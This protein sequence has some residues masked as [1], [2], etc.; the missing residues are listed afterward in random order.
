[1]L[2]SGH[3]KLLSKREN[4]TKNFWKHALCSQKCVYINF[5]QFRLIP[6]V[7]VTVGIPIV[8]KSPHYTI[9][10]RSWQV[11]SRI[12]HRLSGW[13]LISVAV[14][15]LHTLLL[16][17]LAQITDKIKTL[18]VTLDN[19]LTFDHHVSSISKSCFF[20]IRAFRHIRAALTQEMANSVAVSLVTS[21]LDN[22][23]S[24]LY[25]TSQ[26]NLNKLQRIQNT[27]TK[28]VDP[29]HT[30]SSEAL[31]TL[32]WF[33]VRQRINFKIATLTFKLL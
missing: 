26:T 23:N 12:N 7:L 5:R 10:A 2:I 13:A 28:L 24:L 17:L 3:V 29:N 20:H 1:M 15:Y 21:R 8:T 32:H 30:C 27:L 25:G 4:N 18:G 22:A 33:P 11:T 14:H 19:R 9:G 16:M 6:G 31:Q